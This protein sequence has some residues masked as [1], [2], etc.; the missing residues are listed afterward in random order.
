MFS[1]RKKSVPLTNKTRDIE[2][3]QTWEVRWKSR[4]GDFSGCLRPE[5]EVFTSKEE[6]VKF[7]ESLEAAAKLLKYTEFMRIATIEKRQ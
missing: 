7:K 1:F 6:A 3:A 4:Y 2:V 5:V